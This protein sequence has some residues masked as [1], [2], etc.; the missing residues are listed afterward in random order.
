M[1]SLCLLA[2]LFVCLF[3][4]FWCCIVHRCSPKLGSYYPSNRPPAL[5]LSGS[6]PPR[7]LYVVDWGLTE[8]IADRVCQRVYRSLSVVRLFVCLSVW[9]GPIR[10]SQ[11]PVTHTF[12]HKSTQEHV[13]ERDVEE[14]LGTSAATAACDVTKQFS[15][16]CHAAARPSLGS[17]DC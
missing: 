4:S 17:I 15:N 10:A 14:R 2:C 7:P 16:W 12:H 9:H 13:A 8:F 6:P 1:P 11:Y 5:L 3:C